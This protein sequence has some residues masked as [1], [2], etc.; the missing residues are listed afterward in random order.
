VRHAF[1]FTERY[2]EE[3]SRHAAARIISPSNVAVFSAALRRCRR[4][5]S[6]SRDRFVRQVMQPAATI[7]TLSLNMREQH[8]EAE[9]W[10][11]Q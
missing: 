6:P 11:Q 9:E 2:G 5:G 7:F 3:Y 10:K 4:H 8:K 1:A